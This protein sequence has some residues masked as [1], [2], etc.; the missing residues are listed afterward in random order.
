MGLFLVYK[1]TSQWKLPRGICYKI[2]IATHFIQLYFTRIREPFQLKDSFQLKD[3]F[4]LW[5]PLINLNALCVLMWKG[6]DWWMKE[7]RRRN[8]TRD[9]LSRFRTR[10]LSHPNHRCKSLRIGDGIA[11]RFRG[12]IWVHRV[13][14]RVC[15]YRRWSC[16]L[17][18]YF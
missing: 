3:C 17:E 18:W 9:V 7:D 4:D 16:W 1:L 15:L 8:R 5:T 6:R 10:D 11:H 13:L 14:S 2:N 12:Y